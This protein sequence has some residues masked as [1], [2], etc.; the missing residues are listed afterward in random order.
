MFLTCSVMLQLLLCMKA[1]AYSMPTRFATL[2]APLQ[3]PCTCIALTRSRVAHSASGRAAW[4]QAAWPMFAIGIVAL[5]WSGCSGAW[6][7]NCFLG[8][9]PATEQEKAQNAATAT[10]YFH[11]MLVGATGLMA[12]ALS[13]WSLRGTP[14]RWQLNRGATSMWM[15]M[16]SQW[17]CALLYTIAVVRVIVQGRQ[18]SSVFRSGIWR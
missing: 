13:N 3:A 1:A 14:E 11:F 10:A 15:K 6:S 9:D 8:E 12:M 2:S 17:V 5:L 18:R 4:L 7:Y 16:A